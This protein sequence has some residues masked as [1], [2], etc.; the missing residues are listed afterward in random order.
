MIIIILLC[1]SIGWVCMIYDLN[2]IKDSCEKIEADMNTI[3]VKVSYI[4]R[5]LLI[6]EIE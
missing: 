6:G 5:E 3:K 2:K 4:E 1:V